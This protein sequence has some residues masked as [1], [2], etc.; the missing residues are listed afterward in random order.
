MICPA[1]DR[2]GSFIAGRGCRAACEDA[3][4]GEKNKMNVEAMSIW[5]EAAIV[6]AAASIFIQLFGKSDKKEG[7]EK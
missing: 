4:R 2:C 3:V 1:S 6:L 5:D 7:D